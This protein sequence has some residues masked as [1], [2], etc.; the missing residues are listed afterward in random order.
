MLAATCGPAVLGGAEG[1]EHALAGMGR[2]RPARAFGIALVFLSLA[3]APP[4]AGF[5]GE[6]AVAA[7]LAQS[8][9]FALLALGLLGT[10]LS[11]AAALG[12]LRVLYIQSPPE[13]GRR[14]A[15]F[16]LPGLTFVS[17]AGAVSLCLAILAVGAFA[18]PIM[19]LAYQGAEA[20]TLR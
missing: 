20:L 3:G 9:D 12:T 17:S 8:G 5:F 13:E 7:A 16:A 14:A 6:F 2:L 1:G 10:V 11:L 19:G 18:N 4:L 15:G